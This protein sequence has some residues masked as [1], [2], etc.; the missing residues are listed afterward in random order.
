MKFT[1]EIEETK[2]ACFTEGARE[3]LVSRSKEMAKK[4]ID[5]ACRVEAVRRESDA[6]QEITQADVIEGARSTKKRPHR[7]TWWQCVMKGV[8]PTLAAIPGFVFDKEKVGTIIFT[9]IVAV[10]VTAC[11][12]YLI[13]EDNKND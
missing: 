11:T 12:I 4:L 6:K 5:E 13:M 8:C 1:I 2:V 3:E 7:Q 10:I 9:L